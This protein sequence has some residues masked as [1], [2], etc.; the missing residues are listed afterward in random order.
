MPFNWRKLISGKWGDIDWCDRNIKPADMSDEEIVEAAG[1]V[2]CNCTALVELFDE[3]GKRRLAGVVPVARRHIHSADRFVATSA[4]YVLGG[5]GD[6]SDVELLAKA[7]AKP[8]D[9]YHLAALLEAIVMGAPERGDW[10]LQFAADRP[11]RLEGNFLSAAVIVALVHC[12]PDD[13]P[14]L[15]DRLL[16]WA[17][18]ERL[19]P[20]QRYDVFYRL[21]AVPRTER[22][23]DFFVAFYSSDDGDHP[24]LTEIVN[25]ALRTAS[26]GDGG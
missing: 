23:E 21:A 6:P 17:A 26:S 7:T 24:E 5:V 19:V 16:E 18:D 25:E 11:V 10:A 2:K 22:I 3:A 1:K 13:A 4:A 15:E 9:V 14:G 20:E 8:T 12:L